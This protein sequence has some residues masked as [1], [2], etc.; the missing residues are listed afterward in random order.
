VPCAES[1]RREQRGELLAESDGGVRAAWL[2]RV[3]RLR[4][5]SL[6]QHEEQF[7]ARLEVLV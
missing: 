1:D 6:G 7:L 3:R 5:H 2:L 4:S